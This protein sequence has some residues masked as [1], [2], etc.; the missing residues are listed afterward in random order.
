MC[1]GVW[2]VTD[3]RLG[4]EATAPAKRSQVQKG[5][6]GAR[7]AVRVPAYTLYPVRI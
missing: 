1:V 5:G 6:A 7:R 3:L 4:D 2:G